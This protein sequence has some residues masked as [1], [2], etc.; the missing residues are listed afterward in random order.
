VSGIDRVAIIGLDC[1][2]PVLTFER[3]IEELPTIRRLAEAGTFGNLQ[4][5]VPPI[6]V[7]AW[8]CMACSQDPGT[9][10]VYGFRNRADYSYDNLTIASSLAVREAR[11]WE[12]LGEAGKQ[13]IILGVPQTYP[14]TRPVNGCMVTSFLT[15]SL[16]SEYTFPA[17]LKAEI[18]QV[19]G[20]YMFDVKGF[21]TQNKRWLLEQI[22]EM[23]DKRFRLAK[24]LV[25]TRPWD[26]FWM[27][28]MGHDRMHHGFWQFMDAQH[29][30]YEPGNEFEHAI[31][32]Y[33][34]HCD[35][36]LGDLLE[37]MDLD[38]TAVWVVSD[39][40]AKRMEGGICFNDWLIQK[41]YL[42]LKQSPSGPTRFSYD[43]VDWSRTVAWGEGG[44]Y[45]RC[46]INLAG[47]E[48]LG[49]VRAGAYEE[50]RETLMGQIAAIPDA[51]GR[52]MATRV[53]KPQQIY[54]QVNGVAPDLVVLFGDLQWRSVGTVGNP[55]IH[56]FEN[57]TGP[58]DANHALMGM[59]L[60][61]H[62]SIP[63]GGRMDGATIYDVA[64]T[65]LTMLGQ[66]IPAGMRG[67]SLV[68][69]D[70]QP[71]GRVE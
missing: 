26:L 70:R 54:R 48:P 67:R 33:Y 2:D 39:H 10:G 69:P 35:A 56:T 60:F 62:P 28:E 41:G 11:L 49:Q 14:I 71:V 52:P 27:V 16:E 46:F 61:R 42:T 31:R 8:M 21:R 50:L 53:H 66:A 59:Y 45:A 30:R 37:A 64:P 17:D 15:P 34:K 9:L 5:C 65:V 13:A 57:D 4:S 36:L 68:G 51:A 22:Y 38:A 58:D 18:A 24:H 43:M 47:R 29:H 20:P 32:D 1:A 6:T 44:Y 23:T 19:V 55:A 40:G 25:G 7:P 12:L 3:F 63:P